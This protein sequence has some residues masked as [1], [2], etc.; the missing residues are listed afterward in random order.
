MQILNSRNDINTLLLKKTRSIVLT[1]L[2]VP[3]GNNRYCRPELLVY[4][5]RCWCTGQQRNAREFAGERQAPPSPPL[6]IARR[7]MRTEKWRTGLRRNQL[8]RDREPRSFEVE[9]PPL[10]KPSGKLPEAYVCACV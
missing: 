7:A 9:Q 5:E 2:P 1:E 10:D 6:E 4:N 8:C 3:I